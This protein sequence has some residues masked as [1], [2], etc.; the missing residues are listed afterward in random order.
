M[1]LSVLMPVYNEEETL[2]MI[3]DRVMV[4][5]VSG[6]DDT[7][8]VIVDDC[9]QDNS[10]A[11]IEKL[12]AKYP[13]RIKAVFHT[14]NQGKGAAFRTAVENMTGDIC[15]IQDADLEYDPS[16]YGLMLEPI[17]NH[18]ADCVYGSRF[19]GS[20]AKRVLFFWHYAGNKF[21]TL[22]SN[23]LTNLNLTDIE[24][25]YKAFRGDV[26]RSIPIRCNGFSVDP[27]ITAKIARRKFR[28]FEVGIS[29]NG[30]TYAE[31]KKITWVDGFRAIFTILRFA[32]TD[33]SRKK[34]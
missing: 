16:E 6:I 4:Q 10:K 27:E 31:G 28:I 5:A 25:C 3:T 1:K 23:M 21:L 33:D 11:I 26:I 17:I 13:G 18:R 9:S 2:E 14:R 19:V 29:Y 24:T 15:I 7:E 12:S 32:L 30:R 34:S 20:K 8:L 22:L